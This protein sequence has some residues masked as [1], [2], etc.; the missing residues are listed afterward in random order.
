[1]GKQEAIMPGTEEFIR[2]FTRHERQIRYYIASL[3]VNKSDVDDIM[4]EASSLLWKKFDLYDPERPFLPWAMRF[5][6]NAVRT[7][8]QKL[9]TRHK[10]FS[11]ELVEE[12]VAAHEKEMDR[13]E[14]ERRLLPAALTKLSD[15]ERLLVEHRYSNGGTIQDLAEKLGETPDALYKRLQRIREKLMANIQMELEAI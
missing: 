5:A 7:Y 12:L 11:D 8:R 1:V 14:Q 3:V 2:Q 9:S 15:R 10:Y 4:Q 13:L 6:Y